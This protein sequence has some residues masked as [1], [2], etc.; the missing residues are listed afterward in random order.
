[1]VLQLQADR[2]PAQP[3]SIFADVATRCP[4]VQLEWITHAGH[5]DN[6][7]QPAK[8]ADAINRFVRAVSPP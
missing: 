3:P 4:T 7:D 2:D 1:V 5:V 6:F 8:V